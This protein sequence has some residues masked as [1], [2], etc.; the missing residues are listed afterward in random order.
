MASRRNRTDPPSSDTSS[1]ASSN[2]GWNGVPLISAGAWLQSYIEPI[3]GRSRKYGCVGVA[4]RGTATRNST[5]AIDPGATV[6]VGR[7]SRST[8]HPGGAEIDTS[9]TPTS[10]GPPLKKLTVTE[11]TCPGVSF[12]S[13]ITASMTSPALMPMVRSRRSRRRPDVPG[14]CAINSG[15]RVPRLAGSTAPRAVAANRISG[16]GWSGM[17]ENRS[18]DPSVEPPA[19]RSAINR[20]RVCR[21]P[22]GC[23][24]PMS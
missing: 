8:A 3:K 4:S 6:S 2:G 11:T 18:S 20:S 17:P 15:V 23:N 1:R 21:G 10:N 13:A 5:V 9:S 7:G 22:M 19:A 12:S 24:T 14:S 16:V